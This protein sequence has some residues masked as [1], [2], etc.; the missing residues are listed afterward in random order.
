MH[1]NH[2]DTTPFWLTGARTHHYAPLDRDLHV[3]A[4]V[5][6]GGITGLTAAYLLKQAGRTVALIERRR[7]AESETGH[8]TAHLTAVTDHSLSHLVGSLG[9]DH[10]T[11]TW[12]AGFAAIAQIQE[13]V[14]SEHIECDFSWVPGYLYASASQDK[15]EARAQCG[16]EA[17]IATRLGFDAT[18]VDE[19]PVFGA[20]AVRYEGQARFHPAKYLGALIERIPGE[21]CFVFEDTEVDE[22]DDRPL[23]IRCGPH[24]VQAEFLVMATHVPLSSGAG[25][26][27]ATLLQTD[28]F[29]YSSYAVHGRVPKGTLPEGLY[30]EN[31]A[32]AYDYLRVD[33]CSGYQDV[34]LG[35]EDH[36]TGQADDTRRCFAAIE[37]RLREYAPGIRIMHRWSGQVIETR[38]GLPYI[39]EVSPG[40]FVATGFAGNGMTFGTIAGMMAADALAGRT[41]PW[42]KLFDARRTRLLTGAWNYVKENK[43]YPY[44]MI[45]D[46]FAGAEGKSLRAVQRGEGKLIDLNGKRAAV[47]RDARGQVTMLSPSCTHLGCHVEWNTAE[48]TWDCPCHGSRFT[49]EGRVLAGPAERPLPPHEDLR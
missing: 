19:A 42:A 35:G 22:V 4:V 24:T 31:S 21:G 40:R 20:P 17:E 23:R 46:R 7:I 41:S 16:Q 45:R 14:L 49:T 36:K 38:D 34:I 27:R 39:G 15:D 33:A 6:G 32:G 18:L 28:L 13:I 30:W 11:A 10:A 44:Y 29:A 12:D 1:T 8:T 47:Y 5:I 26:V 37:R 25:A 9:D 3:D 2:L 43:D 48:Q